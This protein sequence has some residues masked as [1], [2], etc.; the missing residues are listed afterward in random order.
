MIRQKMAIC[1]WFD[2]Q[3][4]AAANY[5]CSIFQNSS[6]NKVS[7][8]GH[9]GYEHH[10]KE[11]GTVMTIEF[12]INGMDFVG[13]NGGKQFAF[14]EA[15]SIAV[16]CESQEEIDHIWSKLTDGGHEQPCGWLKDRFGVS[17]Q[18]IPTILVKLL[19]GENN[20]L[21]DRVTNAVLKMKK[22][23]IADIIKAQRDLK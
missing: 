8:Y 11:A 18:I 15:A 3:A 21:T 5:Y 16:Y 4:E 10:Q 12:S 19:S 7:K 6:V 13:L 1:L 9:E 22:P 2:D 14:N 23:I 20:I 17:W